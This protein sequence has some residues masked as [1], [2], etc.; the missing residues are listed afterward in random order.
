MFFCRFRSSSVVVVTDLV[1]F[2]DGD[3]DLVVV[4]VV[5]F[6]LAKHVL[7]SM[8]HSSFDRVNIYWF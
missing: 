4:V 6:V 5:V 1:V 3:D 7:M 8:F 2:D